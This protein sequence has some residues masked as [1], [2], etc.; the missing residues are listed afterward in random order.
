MASASAT[1]HP[2]RSAEET[3]LVERFAR[4]PADANRRA[5]F[6]AFAKNGLPHRRIEGWRWSDVRAALRGLKTDAADAPADPLH[7]IGHAIHFYDDG[8]PPRGRGEN[9]LELFDWAEGPVL[10]HAADIP[11]GALGAALADAP[12]MTGVNI[13]VDTKQP[14]R[15]HFESRH[16]GQ[17]R[18]LRVTLRRGVTAHVVET[19][20][21]GAGFS[22][23]LIDYQLEAGATL[24]RTVYQA[25]SKAA[26][27]AS[28]ARV[29]LHQGARLAQTS[30]ALGAKLAR[31]ETRVDHF[32]GGSEAVLN[33]A[34]LVGEGFHADM[35]SHVS[36][37][38]PGCITRQAV[39]GAARAGGKGVFQGKFLVARDAQKTDAEMQHNALLLEEGAEINA[40]PELEIYA[41]DVQC[42]HGNTAGALDAAALF[43]MRQRG[44]PETEAR[45]MLTESFIAEAFEAADPAIADIL[46]EE[47][48]RWL[49]SAT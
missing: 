41:D 4:L 20:V 18:R 14:L 29:E 28:L 9:G 44:I 1:L 22:S 34:Y 5:A 11:L 47:A 8:L 30:L 40:K 48:R 7:A 49:R 15:L 35:T 31:I 23:V 21:A 36:H 12:A 37:A 27:Q 25:G 24:H 43:Y 17:F 19:Y 39:K 3:A 6:E 10:D 45:A 13:A 16:A 2:P 33:G 46:L 32:V 26:V 42:A 38:Q